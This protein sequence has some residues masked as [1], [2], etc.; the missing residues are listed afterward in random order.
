MSRLNERTHRWLNRLMERI[1]RGRLRRELLR[2]TDYTLVD[3]GFS[4][5]LL[6]EGVSAWPW[7]PAADGGSGAVNKPLP[8]IKPTAYRQ[9]IRELRT[10]SDAELADLGLH[11][12]TI[13]Y[14]V[15]HGRPGIDDLDRHAA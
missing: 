4:R 12:S 2:R 11:R 7:R 15:C 6:E 9:A 8:A 14:A 5:D 13:E 10:Y 1:E 3:M